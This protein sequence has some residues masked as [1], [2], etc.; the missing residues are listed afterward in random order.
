MSLRATPNNHLIFIRNTT[1]FANYFQF[2]FYALAC[3]LYLPICSSWPLTLINI[4]T[5]I[6]SSSKV[7]VCHII[8][9]ISKTN[10][11][12]SSS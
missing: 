4:I 11:T 5:I 8:K 9:L 1:M 2:P 6:S 12:K 3:I 7:K 10:N